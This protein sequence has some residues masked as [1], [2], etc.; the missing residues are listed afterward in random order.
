MFDKTV[1][2]VHKWGMYKKGNHGYFIYNKR[3]IGSVNEN[4]RYQR[5]YLWSYLCLNT[6]TMHIC[7]FVSIIYNL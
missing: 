4:D 7:I 5:N 2:L 1:H 6:L 3:F